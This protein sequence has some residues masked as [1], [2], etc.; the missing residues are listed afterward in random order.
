MKDAGYRKGFDLKS[1]L[2]QN[3]FSF[4]SKCLQFYIKMSSVLHQ[5][6]DSSMVLA[7]ENHRKS[8]KI[9]ILPLKNNDFWQTDER[10]RR[11][12]PGNHGGDQRMTFII[13]KHKAHH[14]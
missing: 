7:L 3:V 8:S 12:A 5:N 11:A 14:F 9:M 4:T 2:H 10:P 13:F 6:D 1:V